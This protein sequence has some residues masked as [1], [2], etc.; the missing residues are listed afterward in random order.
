VPP[1][2]ITGAPDTPPTIIITTTTFALALTITCLGHHC[3]HH[4]LLPSSPVITIVT[5][6]WPSFPVTATRPPSHIKFG[7]RGKGVVGNEQRVWPKV[8]E[9]ACGGVQTGW[10]TLLQDTRGASFDL[11]EF[12]RSLRIAACLGLT[13]E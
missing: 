6:H 1:C 12:W 7:G 8:V 5:L 11:E 9:V 2:A 4:L 3:C 10:G 13:G